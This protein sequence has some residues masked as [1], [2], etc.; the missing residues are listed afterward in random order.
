MKI[1]LHNH[2][3]LC[4][5]AEGSISEYVEA[6]ICAG[7][8][9]FGFS[10]HA[11][12]DFDPKYRMKFDEMLLYRAMVMEAKAT[13]AQK[14]EVLLG[15]EVD[16]LPGHMDPRVLDAEVDYLIGSVH[17]IDEWGFD[18]PEF[19]G[20]YEHKEIDVIWQRYFEQV[21]AMAGSGLF[22]IAGHLDLIKVFKFM[23]KG[24]IAAIASKAL[25]A[26]ADMKMVLEINV[27]GYR[28]P[29]TEAYPSMQLLC[30]AHA[31]NIPITFGS[32]AH[33]PTQVG[34]FRAQAEALAR[35]AGYSE[36]VYFR[37]RTPRIVSF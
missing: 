12:M 3:A 28:K 29:V 35:E 26:M 37:N 6:A 34:L 11:P 21:A 30:A 25:D 19:I 5:H 32:D 33:A 20:Q 2:T 22:D 18:N 23:P 10:D 31:R 13:Y 1:D 8:D 36:C 27:A 14:I 24:D 7:I 4:N 16:Y 15:Y 9:V 17:F